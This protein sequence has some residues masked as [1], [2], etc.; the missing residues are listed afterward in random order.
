MPISDK[1]FTNFDLVKSL[2]QRQ[3]ERD[4]VLE[5]IAQDAEKEKQSKGQ[6]RRNRILGNNQEANFKKTKGLKNSLMHIFSKKSSKYCVRVREDKDLD[7]TD[8][9]M[10]DR[11]TTIHVES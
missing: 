7:L 10:H 2:E 4:D 9:K 1:I 8:I 3:K 5:K 11:Q 6:G